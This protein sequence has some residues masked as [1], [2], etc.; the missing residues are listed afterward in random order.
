MARVY[1]LD[2]TLYD[3]ED[4]DLPED[5]IAWIRGIGL[6]ELE[7]F[8]GEELDKEISDFLGV[9]E[10][11]DED[12]LDAPRDLDMDEYFHKIRQDRDN[13][14]HPLYPEQDSGV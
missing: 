11:Q 1:Y 7:D 13:H 14:K 3:T 5:M 2:G 9:P 6:D 10:D 4:K 12:A 8:Q